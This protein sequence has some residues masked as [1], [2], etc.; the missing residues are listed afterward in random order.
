M[1]GRRLLH[2]RA[3]RLGDRANEVLR[4]LLAEDP[5][6][7]AAWRAKEGFYNIWDHRDHR[8]TRELRFRAWDTS[9]AETVRPEFGAVTATVRRG[10]NEVFGYFCRATT[11]RGIFAKD[12]IHLRIHLCLE[13]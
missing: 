12:L 9:I 1:R 4:T 5:I 11:G 13:P 2:A 6:L 3:D 7:E 10:A 8:R